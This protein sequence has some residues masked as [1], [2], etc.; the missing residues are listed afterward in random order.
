MKTNRITIAIFGLVVA[1][2]AVKSCG[3]IK[4]D[5]ASEPI[6]A[7][8]KEVKEETGRLFPF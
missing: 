6:S 7:Q 1:I 8:K 5:Q 3:N 4:E 2:F